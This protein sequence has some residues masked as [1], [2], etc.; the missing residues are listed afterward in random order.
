MLGRVAGT[1]DLGTGHALTGRRPLDH[2]TEAREE[3]LGVV[4]TGGGLGVVLDREDR[5]TVSSANAF[6]AAVE[7]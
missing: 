1:A 4:R 7:Q 3:V 6:Q 2:L 5:T